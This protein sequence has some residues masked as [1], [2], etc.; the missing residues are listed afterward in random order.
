MTIR[1]LLVSLVAALAAASLA[2]A[3]AVLAL[4]SLPHSAR[5]STSVL[6]H[7]L[8]MRSSTVRMPLMTS[9]ALSASRNA[10]FT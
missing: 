9:N 6:M 8:M 1:T 2:A 7:L 10:P 5:A 4:P 3:I